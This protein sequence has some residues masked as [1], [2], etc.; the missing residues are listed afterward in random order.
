LVLA[1][2]PGAAG[3][4]GAERAAL[5]EKPP[6]SGVTEKAPEPAQAATPQPLDSRAPKGN[7]ER[8]TPTQPHSRSYSEGVRLPEGPPPVYHAPEE[9]WAAATAAAEAADKDAW[10]DDDDWLGEESDVETAAA[11]LL[12]SEPGERRVGRRHCCCSGGGPPAADARAWRGMPAWPK[13][14]R[15]LLAGEP[16]SADDGGDGGRGAGG[17]SGGGEHWLPRPVDW[18]G[19]PRRGICATVGRWCLAVFVAVLTIGLFVGLLV[20]AL[21][22]ALFNLLI[23]LLLDR[24][25]RLLVNTFYASRV[26]HAREQLIKLVR[27]GCRCCRDREAHS[28]SIRVDL[29]LNPHRLLPVAGLAAAEAQLSVLGTPG[30]AGGAPPATDGGMAAVHTIAY[31]SDNYCYLIVDRS[32]GARQPYAAALVDPADAECVLEACWEIERREYGGS[33]LSFGDGL[34]LVAILT[35]HKHWDHAAGAPPRSRQLS[36]SLSPTCPL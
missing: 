36:R 27:W 4:A 17:V 35:T 10:L 29:A 14:K 30:V 16:L 11:S 6:R 20:A 3:D 8:P 31:L 15:A 26:G 1:G 13:L 12:R 32:P 23:G 2:T 22:S 19:P 25:V 34:R 33:P 21:V 5:L 18:T 28:W 9:A 24:S 7:G